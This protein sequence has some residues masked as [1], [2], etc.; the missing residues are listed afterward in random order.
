MYHYQYVSRKELAPAKKEIIELLK[1]VQDTVRDKF[2][3]SYEFVG[4]AKR[5]MVTCDRKSN[6]GYDFDV[7]IMVNDD[8]VDYSPKEIK[9]IHAGI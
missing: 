1:L 3:F 7:D 5:N 2:T 6:I 8:D 4:S 9:H